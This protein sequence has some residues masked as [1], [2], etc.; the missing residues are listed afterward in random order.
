MKVVAGRVPD[1]N[2]LNPVSSSDSD[3]SFPFS[4]GSIIVRLPSSEL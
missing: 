3:E 2:S 1:S 4:S